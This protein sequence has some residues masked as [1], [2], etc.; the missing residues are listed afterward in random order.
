M[1]G[2]I[3]QMI[4]TALLMLLIFAITDDRNQPSGILTPLLVGLVV[5]AIGI[6]F[7]RCMA[8]RLTRRDFA[9]LFTV[10][11]G[12]RNNGSRMDRCHS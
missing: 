10:L 5:V 9:R 11:A 1:P 2:F 3:D 7:G 12:F 8:T 4:G 6:S